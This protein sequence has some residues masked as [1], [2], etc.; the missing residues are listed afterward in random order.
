MKENPQK[1]TFSICNLW[2]KVDP[3]L[4]DEIA[5]FW[6]EQKALSD[7]RQAIERTAQVVFLARNSEGKIVGVST[8]YKKWQESL[9]HHFYYMRAF[10]HP[11]YRNQDLGRIFTRAVV[12]FFELQFIT[13]A[14]TEAI[15]IF[16]EIENRFVQE[17][18]RDAILP[19]GDFVYLG[20]NSRGAH[21]RVRYFK[22]AQI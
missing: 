17:N 22:G 20:K 10:V 2:Q 16:L 5:G 18:R 11:D 14:E 4:A 15:G 9:E 8:A 7:V 21:L 3:V 13:G 1:E 19:D 12:S 6:L